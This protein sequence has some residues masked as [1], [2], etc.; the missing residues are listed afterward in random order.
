MRLFKFD[1]SL[2]WIIHVAIIFGL[3]STRILEAVSSYIHR[4]FLSGH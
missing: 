4:K 1:H 2:F 3:S